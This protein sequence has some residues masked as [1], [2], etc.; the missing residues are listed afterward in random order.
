MCMQTWI[1]VATLIVIVLH[2]LRSVWLTLLL[3]VPLVLAQAV[4]TL[5][6]SIAY[7]NRH[8][9]VLVEQVQWSLVGGCVL[10]LLLRRIIGGRCPW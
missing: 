8:D 2:G 6:A 9:A 3:A 10:L 5:N 7:L 1:W 4:M